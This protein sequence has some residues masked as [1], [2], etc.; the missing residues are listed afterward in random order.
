MAILAILFISLVFR[1]P[2]EAHELE[3]R[4]K[5]DLERMRTKSQSLTQ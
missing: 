2:Q 3:K 4:V 1:L 5:E